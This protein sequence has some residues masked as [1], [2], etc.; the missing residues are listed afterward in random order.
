MKQGVSGAPRITRGAGFGAVTVGLLAMLG[1]WLD[2]VV[3]RH[4]VP[5]GVAMNPTSALLFIW[6]GAAL[7]LIWWLAFSLSNTSRDRAEAQEALRLSV[8]LLAEAQSIARM[9][10]WEHDPATGAM[11]CSDELYRLY[12][13]EPRS[14]TPSRETLLK[15]LHPDDAAVLRKNLERGEPFSLT[16]RLDR[17]DGQV[18]ILALRCEVVSD[19]IAHTSRYVGVA[20]DVTE[21]HA[22]E[23]LKD[24][25]ISVVSHEL[26]T[27]L[28]AIRGSLGL[29]ETGH[30][31][32]LAPKGKEMLQVAARNSDRLVRLINDI[33]DV[34]R[35]ASGATVLQPRACTPDDLMPQAVEAMGAMAQ[36]AGVSLVVEP[37]DVAFYGD[38]DRL[39]QVLTNLIHNAVKF[40]SSGSTVRIGA[41]AVDGEVRFHVADA[42]RGIPPEFLERIF[43]RFGQVD[44][45]DSRTEG[46]TGLGLTIC[47]SI[48][49]LHG[50][51][52]WATSVLGVGSTFYVA[53]PMKP[54]S[55]PGG[56]A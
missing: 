33:L 39:L 1:W 48:L 51:R 43:E 12:G 35:M 19:P 10:S 6:L 52:I 34:E 28:T 23:R 49:H 45:S 29:L 3:L 38:A 27:P 30:L 40:S 26:R 50:G 55:P 20:Q 8:A 32:E 31:G 16:I 36:K 18:R 47:R 21:Q 44:A 13:W 41:V 37:C 22:V 11:A 24:E 42:G 2:I 4:L 14:V 15:Q 9:G 7:G 46:G 25:F 53:L 17:P 56:P 5:E 54:A